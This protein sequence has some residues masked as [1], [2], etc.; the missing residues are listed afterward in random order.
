VVVMMMMIMVV[1]M[2]VTRRT[3]RRLLLMR[4][5]LVLECSRCWCFGVCACVWCTGAV[6]PVVLVQRAAG[7]PEP[8]HRRPADD[9]GQSVT[10][11]TAV[12]TANTPEALIGCGLKYWRSGFGSKG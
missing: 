8:A 1:A 10:G 5:M 6:V 9:H 12:T 7:G 2:M 4:F 3:R 11:V